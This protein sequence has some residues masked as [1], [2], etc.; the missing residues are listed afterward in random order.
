MGR[1][2]GSTNKAKTPE[3]FLLDEETRLKIIAS[4]VVDMVIEEM[5]QESEVGCEE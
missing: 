2:K 4:L 1:K 3:V 5:A